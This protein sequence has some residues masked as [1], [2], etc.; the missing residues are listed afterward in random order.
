MMIFEELI[1]A[2]GTGY[3]LVSIYAIMP[4]DIHKK[5]R[6]NLPHTSSLR[7][8]RTHG[9]YLIE[10]L[11]ERWRERDR[12]QR[13]LESDICQSQNLIEKLSEL[14]KKKSVHTLGFQREIQIAR[15]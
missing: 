5:D 11:H 13:V 7:T 15:D 1:E 14:R 3:D 10:D 12:Y 2:F 9:L 8:E 6:R 4:I